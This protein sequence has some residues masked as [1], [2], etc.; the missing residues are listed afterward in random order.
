MELLAAIDLRAGAAVRLVQGDFDR[1]SDYGDPVTL[2]HRFLDDGARWL[3][4]VDLD[5]ARTG[6]R[7]NQATVEAIAAAAS[8]RSAHIE[9]SGGIRSGD[10]VEVLLRLGVDRVVLGTTAVEDP[11]AAVEWARL[12]PGAVGVGLDYRRHPGGMLEAASRGWTEGSGRGVLEV[13]DA[14]AEAPF[15]AVVVTAIDRDGTLGGP[16][17][18]GLQAI[19]DA[20]RLPV[21]A[22]GG[23]GSVADLRSLSELRGE[24]SGRRLLGAVVGKA[25]VDGRL[26]VAEGRAACEP[27]G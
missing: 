7:E 26:S 27:S 3:H 4:V 1:Q 11:A 5:A 10:D 24:G 8:G 25:L 22:S 12:R 18:Q 9:A 17:L 2:A 14:I 16:D 19:L 20:T 13:L 23:V 15:G 21:V 6:V